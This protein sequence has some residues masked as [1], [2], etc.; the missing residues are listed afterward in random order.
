MQRRNKNDQLITAASLG[1]AVTDTVQL[2][3]KFR[4]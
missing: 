4:V 1:E 3:M 2:L